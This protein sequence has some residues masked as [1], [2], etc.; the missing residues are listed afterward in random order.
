MCFVNKVRITYSCYNVC[1][2][3]FPTEHWQEIFV[4]LFL[5][6]H[7]ISNVNANFFFSIIIQT[8]LIHVSLYFFII[9]IIPTLLIRVSHDYFTIALLI[10][11]N[12]TT[13]RIRITYSCYNV[14]FKEFPTEHWQETF[15]SLFLYLQF[16]RFLMLMRIYCFCPSSSQLS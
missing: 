16:A 3:E 13:L 14:C 12:I 5:Y 15:V 8:Q 6:L 2:K 9:T 10:S 11:L 7:Q 1:F 4:S